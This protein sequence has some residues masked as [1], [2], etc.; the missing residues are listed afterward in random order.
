MSASSASR[1]LIS[2]SKYKVFLFDIEGTT[3]PIVFVAN[4]LF[5]YIRNTLQ[6]YLSQTWNEE[7]TR[8]DVRALREQAEKDKH[9]ENFKDAPLIDPESQQSIIDNVFYNMNKDRKMT[10]LKQLQGHMWKSGY[11]NGQLRGELYDDAFHFFERIRDHSCKI[12]IYSSGSVQAQ[13]LLFQYSTHGNLLP[14]ISDHFDTSNIGNKLEKESYEKIVDKIGVN[15]SEILF[16]TDNIGEAEAARE[17]GVD[18]VLSVRPGTKA[19]PENHT[20]EAVTSFN[21]LEFC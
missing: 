13:K 14:F 20:F 2:V 3:T 11:E 19:L 9:D 6:N 4:T 18:A 12:Y 21:D 17:A 15:K 10:A 5:P 1:R 8:N 7:Q 16:L